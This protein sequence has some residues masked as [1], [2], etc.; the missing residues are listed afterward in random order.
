[1]KIYSAPLQGFTEAVW[2]NLHNG[3]IGGIE[4]YFTPFIRYEHGEIRNKDIRDVEKKNNT[5]TNLVPQIIAATPDEMQPLVQ[6]LKN[7]GYRQIDINMG[8]SFPLQ[9]RKCH[10][11]GILPHPDMVTA[12]MAEVKNNSDITFSVKMR[13]GWDNAN[14][15]EALIG[16]LNDTPLSHITMHPRLGRE[17]YKQPADIDAFKAFNNKCRHPV[18]YNGDI[19][20]LADIERITTNFPALQ[21]VMIG[22]GLL[23]NPALGLE[24]ERGSELSLDEMRHLVEG[25]HDAFFRTMSAR[26][27]GNTQL[28]SKLKPY[29][30]YLLPEMEK[31]YRKAILKATTADKYLQAVENALASLQNT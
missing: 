31:R 30:E 2:R 3:F 9:A 20:T 15:W 24:Y 14:E 18:I 25:M 23:A 29:W 13:L 11:A 27:Q 5:V 16:I 22:R 28:L 6:L 7:E 12:L 1:M 26:L 8:C 4:S 10:G 17:Q 19:N 21:G